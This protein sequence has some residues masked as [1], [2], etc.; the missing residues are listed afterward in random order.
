MEQSAHQTVKSFGEFI[1]LFKIVPALTI[2]LIKTFW[3]I[4]YP[5]W[6]VMFLLDDEYFKAAIKGWKLIFQLGGYFFN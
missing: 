4:G 6:V 1:C 5:L 2:M 3:A